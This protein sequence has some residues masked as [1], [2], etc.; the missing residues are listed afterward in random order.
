L[1]AYRTSDGLTGTTFS[2]LGKIR[3]PD[4]SPTIIAESSAPWQLIALTP[5]GKRFAAIRFAGNT[6]FVS[7]WENTPEGIDPLFQFSVAHRNDMY[8]FFTDAH[9]SSAK[10]VSSNQLATLSSRS[11]LHSWMV[12]PKSVREVAFIPGAQK[13]TIGGKGELVAISLPGK[14]VLLNGTLKEQVGLILTNC[15][16]YS[17]IAFS[18][19]GKYLAV[20][21]PFNVRIYRL[22]DGEIHA[23]IPTP[24]QDST[25]P[26]DW[27]G[28]Y[29]LLNKELLLDVEHKMPIWKYVAPDDAVPDFLA[30]TSMLDWK[31]GSG[32]ESF[33]AFANRNGDVW[34]VVARIGP[35]IAEVDP[36]TIHNPR[37][38]VWAGQLFTMFRNQSTSIVATTIP[39][40]GALDSLKSFDFESMIALKPGC[41]VQIDANFEN[42]TDQDKETAIQSLENSLK[43]RGWNVQQGSENLVTIS[44]RKL[45][46]RKLTLQVDRTKSE[47]NYSP[48]QYSIIFEVKNHRVLEWKEEVHVLGTTLPNEPLQQFVDRITRFNPNF[49]GSA[50]LPTQI[51]WPKYQWGIGESRIEPTAKLTSKSNDGP[52]SQPTRRRRD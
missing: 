22:A 11:V 23:S 7:F 27:V 1:N 26:L 29:C 18:P 47:I 41:N 31:S 28:D 13:I 30:N 48:M 20:G 4:G 43:H 33:Q 46:S 34:D 10:F 51:L 25:L 8:G 24:T 19:C 21:T 12:R 40:E 52:D 32:V 15:E 14:I 39:H 6:P 50:V 38:A 35:R 45:P 9:T 3:F 37:Q 49:F 17:S 5:D 42:A 36:R 44:A 16:Q 2:A